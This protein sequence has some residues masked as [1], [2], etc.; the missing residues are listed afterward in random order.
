MSRNHRKY[1]KR[2]KEDKEY[3][4]DKKYK[5]EKKYKTE[6]DEEEEEEGVDI[7]T[8]RIYI[9]NLDYSVSWQDLKDYMRKA[10]EVHFAKILTNYDGYSKGCGIVEF[11]TIEDA[12]NAYKELNE[13]EFQGRTIYIR[14]DREDF[15]YKGNRTSHKKGRQIHVDNLPFSMNWRELKDHFAEAGDIERADMLMSRGKPKGAGT[16]L[17]STKEEAQKAIQSF[18]ETKFAGRTINVKMDDYFD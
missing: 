16:I 1:E 8:N 6:Y 15:K 12:K 5:E 18:N 11:E 13:T 7:T 2:S 9:S 14:E 4:K 17:F 10:G 3:K